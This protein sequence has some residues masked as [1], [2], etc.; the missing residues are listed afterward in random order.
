MLDQLLLTPMLMPTLAILS[1]ALDRS[2]RPRQTVEHSLWSIITGSWL[3]LGTSKLLN[4]SIV[5]RHFQVLFANG[6]L[7]IWYTLLSYNTHKVCSSEHS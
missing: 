4:F 3:L 5:P 2:A 7:A 1:A 6:V